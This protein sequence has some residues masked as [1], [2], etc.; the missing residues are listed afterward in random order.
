MQADRA[1][2]TGPQSK[3]TEPQSVQTNRDRNI[4]S[5]ADTNKWMAN[6]GQC[7]TNAGQWWPMLAKWKTNAGRMVA[8]AGRPSVVTDRGRRGGLV[9]SLAVVDDT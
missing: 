9:Y 8:N 5:E 3:T 2:A 7:M 1:V 4:R 6:A